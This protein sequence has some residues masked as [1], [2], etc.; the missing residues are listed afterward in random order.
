MFKVHE[1]NLI[2]FHHFREPRTIVI[3]KGNTGLG[4]NIVGGE[5]G[6]VVCIKPEFDFAWFFYVN[7]CDFFSSNLPHVCENL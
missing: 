7:A 2:S 1:L 3:H 4:F 5:D 6:Q